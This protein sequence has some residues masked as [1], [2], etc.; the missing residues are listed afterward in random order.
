VFHRP[1][2]TPPIKITLKSVY[3]MIVSCL[4]RW[5]PGSDNKPETHVSPLFYAF[6]K[7]FNP[8]DVKSAVSELVVA[9]KNCFNRVHHYAAMNEPEMFFK[10]IFVLATLS[11]WG[12]YLVRSSYGDDDDGTMGIADPDVN[13]EILD[14]IANARLEL[15]DRIQAFGEREQVPAQQISMMMHEHMNIGGLFLRLHL[16][17]HDLA[18]VLSYKSRQQQLTFAEI[19]TAHTRETAYICCSILMAFLS[20]EH[21][22]ILVNKFRPTVP[23]ELRNVFELDPVAE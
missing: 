12:L 23:E 13:E 4:G 11:I 21:W 1:N 5:Y 9:F 16:I 7:S 6:R 20:K 18:H 17:E 22:L 14:I 19:F 8:N 2:Q 3:A 15:V 10:E